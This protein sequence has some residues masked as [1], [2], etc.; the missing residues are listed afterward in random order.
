MVRE[1]E[2]AP[3]AVAPE[4][5]PVLIAAAAGKRKNEDD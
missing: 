4:S 1:K 2:T 5:K 3:T